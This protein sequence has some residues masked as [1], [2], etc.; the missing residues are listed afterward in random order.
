MKWN[1]IAIHWIEFNVNDLNV[2]LN[3]LTLAVIQTEVTSSVVDAPYPPAVVDVPAPV[4]V[5]PEMPAPVYGPREFPFWHETKSLFVFSFHYPKKKYF[6]SSI[7]AQV[8][9][10]PYPASLRVATHYGDPIVQ[11]LQVFKK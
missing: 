3:C 7:A 1:K 4:V 6:H 5:V 11:V 9:D 10:A 8:I 2:P